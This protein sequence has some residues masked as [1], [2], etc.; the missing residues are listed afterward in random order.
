[1]SAESAAQDDIKKYNLW[2]MSANEHTHNSSCRF[3]YEFLGGMR[4][5]KPSQCSRT[6]L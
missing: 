3:Q 5:R 1:M 6:R 4:L 2:I